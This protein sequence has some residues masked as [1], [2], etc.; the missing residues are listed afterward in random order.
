MARRTALITGRNGTQGDMTTRDNEIE[1]LIPALRRY[2]Y[3]LVRHQQ[4][5]DDL[6]Q[7]CLER[8]LSVW[9]QHRADGELRAW[10][11]AILHNRHLD[12]CRQSA[13]RGRDVQIDVVDMPAHPADQLARLEARDALSALGMLSEEHRAVLLLIGVEELSYEEA[14][15]VL[16][17][18]LGTVMSRLSRARQQLRLLTGD[19]ETL[20]LRRV[21]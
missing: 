17:I 9:W 21:K 2:A 10:L 7:D 13:R 5:A 15:R 18:P 4:R 14:G 3:G 6:V 1:R 8:A 12:L 11:F 16:G 20:R 19:G